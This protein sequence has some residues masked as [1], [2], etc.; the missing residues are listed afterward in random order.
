MA[1]SFEVDGTE[2]T[3]TFEY[4]AD[5]TKVQQVI[6]DAAHYLFDRGYGQAE[7]GEEQIEFDDLTAQQKLGL[8]DE[9]VKR[10][11][12]SYAKSYSSDEAQ[13]D[14]KEQAKQDAEDNYDL[15]EE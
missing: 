4:T 8:V 14:A 3:V 1:G 9:Q 13:E 6:F 2:T 15:G 11:I 12:L 7:E 10:S 5:L